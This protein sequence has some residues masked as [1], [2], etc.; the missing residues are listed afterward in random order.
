MRKST[1]DKAKILMKKR[2]FSVA[3]A[4]LE[5]STVAGYYHQHFDY[6][7]TAGIACL[8]L[9]DVGNA[10]A[11]FDKARRL[12]TTDPTLLNAQAALFLR[13]GNTIDAT[14]YY[15]DALQYDPENKLSKFGL[16]FIKNKGTPEEIARVLDCGEIERFYPPLGLNPDIITFSVFAAILG[17]AVAF[18]VLFFSGKFTSKESS[19]GIDWEGYS[20][21]NYSDFFDEDGQSV[22]VMK[23][24]E[25]KKT[26]QKMK[27]LIEV[28]RDNAARVE[29]NRLLNSNASSEL[30][31]QALE[32]AK[33]LDEP[34]LADLKD[35]FSPNQVLQDPILYSGCFVY[36]EG[37]VMNEVVDNNSYHFDLVIESENNTRM[38]AIPVRFSYVPVPPVDPK[39]PIKIYGSINFEN[40]RI[41]L[42]GKSLFQSIR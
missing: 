40:G 10:K 8:Y 14:M 23:D 20:F 32:A 19:R 18:A 11:Y 2:N 25:L 24:G 6:F 3:L 17:I 38:M 4:M 21:S 42:N 9:G 35:K 12:K 34:D 39:K 31:N 33:L 30:K 41:F 1:L 5:D 26:W 37:R 13:R 7:L 15:L 22:Y 29:I 16:D 27:D 28:S 36:W